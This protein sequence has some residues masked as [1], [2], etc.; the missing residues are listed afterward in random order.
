M[1]MAM[2]MV[3]TAVATRRCPP[4][5]GSLH[6]RR[7]HQRLRGLLRFGHLLS[8]SRERRV[9]GRVLRSSAESVRVLHA[10]RD[11]RRALRRHV[12]RRR[13]L[14]AQDRRVPRQR[15]HARV[16]GR[17]L[18]VVALP[19]RDPLAMRY[20]ARGRVHLLRPVNHGARSSTGAHVETPAPTMPYGTRSSTIECSP[21]AR[22][23]ACTCVRSP[24]NVTNT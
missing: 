1:V 2:V 18:R 7:A 20:R 23:T 22:L 12:R 3:A 8:E 15:V 9:A 19:M 6:R 24:G 4:N 10:R 5:A 11:V 21:V 17:V 13:Q 14:R 16:P